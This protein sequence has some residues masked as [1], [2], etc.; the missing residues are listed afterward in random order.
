[1]DIKQVQWAMGHDWYVYS[2]KLSTTGEY[3]VSVKDDMI[4]GHTLK[5]TNFLELY[6]WA[7]Y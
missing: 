7:G 3:I 6:N 4:A 1:M 5:F 2:A